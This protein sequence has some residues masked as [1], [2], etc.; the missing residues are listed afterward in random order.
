MPRLLNRRS[1]GISPDVSSDATATSDLPDEPPS[2]S[3]NNSLAPA[4]LARRTL[5]ALNRIYSRCYH[6]L[7]VRTPC[8]LPRTG[9]AI[10]VCNHTSGLDPLLIQSAA[11]RFIRWMMASEY[12]EQPA[13]RRFFDLIETIPVDRTGRDVA[14]TRAALRAL[15][16]GRI[17]GLFPEG[18]IE[19][20]RELLPF[21]T[22]VAL[23]AAK[24]GAPLYPAYLDGTQRRYDMV[25]SFLHAQRATLTFGPRI[26]F[27]STAGKRDLREMTSIIQA[28]VQRLIPSRSSATG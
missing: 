23:M 26:D 10:L 1:A 20:S 16:Q 24:S 14:A 17:L 2:D 3:A 19:P 4:H 25:G 6:R 8:Q 15:Q 5:V 28:A 27:S 12:S 7:D 13:V 22:G 18:R 11:P 9:P 21:H